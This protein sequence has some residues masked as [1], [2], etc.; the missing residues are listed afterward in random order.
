VAN[1]LA[2]GSRIY[3]AIWDR[4]VSYGDGSTPG[5]PCEMWFVPPGFDTSPI[6]IAGVWKRRDG[7][8]SSIGYVEAPLWGAN[9]MS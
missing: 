2:D 9:Q 8:L 5:P 6:P 1:D 4:M 7:S 3:L